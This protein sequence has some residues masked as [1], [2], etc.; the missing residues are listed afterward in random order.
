METTKTVLVVGASRGLGL[1]LVEEY[2]QLGYHVIAT[3]RK[4]SETLSHLQQTYPA[5]LEVVDQ[6]D[7]VNL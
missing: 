6:V 1:A 4:P 3:V 2:C 7:I 5:T